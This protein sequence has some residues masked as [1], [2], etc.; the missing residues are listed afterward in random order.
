MA[1]QVESVLSQEIYPVKG[2]RLATAAAALR[3]RNR[4]EPCLDCDR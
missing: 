1:V 4:D 3:Y 2:V